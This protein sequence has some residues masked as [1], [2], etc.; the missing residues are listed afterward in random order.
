MSSYHLSSLIQN[1]AVKLGTLA[2]YKP[3]PI[4]TSG[5][6][7]TITDTT[8]SLTVNEMLNGLAII[9]YDA[10]GSG[11]APEGEFAR[12][13][14]NTATAISVAT[15]SFSV[16]V[17]ALDEVMVIR[18]KYPLVEWLRGA[19][20]ILKSIGEVPLW[21]TSITLVASQTE[22]TLPATILSPREVWINMSTTSLDK[23]WAEIPTWTIQHAAPGTV[24]TIRIPE[25]YVIADRSL[26]IVYS[27]DHPEV[28]DFD[29]HIDV[30][31]EWA[32]N[33]LAW[34]MV[35]RGG[36]TDKN[37][38]QAEKILAELND[39]ERKLK[40]PNKRSPQTKFL[41]WGSSG[42]DEGNFTTP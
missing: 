40:I 8:L 35:N 33:K 39:S 4:A 21:D 7:S 6:R 22:Y 38:T 1:A 37:R 36:I 15:N 3:S 19:N 26:G 9:T 11:A 28:H 41:T 24:K 27:G 10:G 20:T 13:I 5:D 30:P 16:A 32:S 23:D 25:S 42:G 31:I 34:H 17:A 18:P 14:S 2:I 29:D 12:I